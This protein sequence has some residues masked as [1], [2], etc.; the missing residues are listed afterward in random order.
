MLRQSPMTSAL[1]QP[2]VRSIGETAALR[3]SAAFS[4]LLQWA[5]RTFSGVVFWILASTD[6]AIA[7]WIDLPSAI[8]ETL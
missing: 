3:M 4:S 5:L 8:L 1:G 7:R 6:A 2:L